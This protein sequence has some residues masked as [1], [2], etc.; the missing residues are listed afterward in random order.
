MQDYGLQ[1]QLQA[2]PTFGPVTTQAPFYSAEVY[3]A[4]VWDRNIELKAAYT[5]S[6]KIEMWQ[7][8]FVEI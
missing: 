5:F 6:V 2:F 4:V 1:Y 3:E 8:T 7:L